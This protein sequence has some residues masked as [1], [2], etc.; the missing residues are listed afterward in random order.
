[1]FC[2]HFPWSGILNGGQQLGGVGVGWGG[3]GASGSSTRGKPNRIPA[4]SLGRGGNSVAV[5]QHSVSAFS[6]KK[7]SLITLIQ[8]R[9]DLLSRVERK[10]QRPK[11]G[12]DRKEIS[13]APRGSG[14]FQEDS[15]TN[16][17]NRKVGPNTRRRLLDVAAGEKEF[18]QERYRKGE[19]EHQRPFSQVGNCT[20]RA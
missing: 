7:K 16:L 6:R 12:G 5:H 8:S 2:G 3:V 17:G 20:R 4:S 11:G 10:V 14:M 18:L 1:V 15:K 9:S 19:K 13:S